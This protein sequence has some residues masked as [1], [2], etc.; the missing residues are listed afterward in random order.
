MSNNLIRRVDPL[1]DFFRG[2]F[3]RPVDFG[4]GSLAGLSGEAPQMRVDVKEGANGYEVHAELPGMKKE[5]IHVH[6]DGPVVSISAERKQE[7]EVKEGEK[8]LRTERY[9]GKVSRSFQL[10]Q[11]IDEANASAKFN[12]GVL[13]LSLPKKAEAQAK[14]LTID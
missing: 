4:G 2:F 7:K 9:F 3:V 12:D 6:I 11:E 14:R 1:E 10:G 8:V 5:D 13:E